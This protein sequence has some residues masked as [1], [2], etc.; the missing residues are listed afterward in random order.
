MQ[1]AAQAALNTRG[2]MLCCIFG[3]RGKS[4]RVISTGE[5]SKE[6]K[7]IGRIGNTIGNEKFNVLIK[8]K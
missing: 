4:L 6:S 2:A 5:D 1:H 7:Q 3:R 8:S